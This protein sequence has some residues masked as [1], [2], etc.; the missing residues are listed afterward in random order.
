[1]SRSLPST[2]E[3]DGFD[4]TDDQY[5]P[6]EWLPANVMLGTLNIF[7]PVP[8]ALLGKYDL[9]NIRYFGLSVKNSEHLDLLKSL[10]SLLSK[11]LPKRSHQKV[12]S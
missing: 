11:S 6:K 12:H 2:V 8:E 1:L 4:I 3:I 5:P 7:E 10:T 9:V